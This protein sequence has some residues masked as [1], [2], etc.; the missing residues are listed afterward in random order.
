MLKACLAP[1]YAFVGRLQDNLKSLE[2]KK[3][4]TLRGQAEK[5]AH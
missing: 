4:P 3:Q 1:L 2:V 5:P